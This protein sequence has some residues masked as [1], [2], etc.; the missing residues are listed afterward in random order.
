MNLQQ[1]Y[2]F[3]GT[4][5]KCL[6][7]FIRYRQEHGVYCT[8]CGRI[9]KHYYLDKPK[10]FRCATCGNT[11]SYRAGTLLYKSKMPLM[12]WFLAFYIL[13]NTKKPTS[14]LELQKLIGHKYY[15]PIWMMLH[16]IR[17]AMGTRDDM[18]PLVNLV[19]LDETYIQ[20]NI[21]KKGM[22]KT[23]LKTKQGKGTLKTPVLLMVEKDTYISKKTNL[24]VEYPKYIKAFALDSGWS[25]SDIQDYVSKNVVPSATLRTDSAPYYNI[26]TNPRTKIIASTATQVKLNTFL[27]SLHTAAGNMKRN[28]LGVY[29]SF[30]KDYQ[31]NYLNEFVYRFNRR[32]QKDPFDNIVRLAFNA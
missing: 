15:E 4:N 18:Y 1:F 19:E 16:K 2:K 30:H 7:Y 32:N 13:A 10:K 26:L 14:A 3:F 21:M 11:I 28:F 31:Q 24:P 20:A 27:G 8:K 17:F 6:R 5:A 12:Y 9:E 23:T 25:G 29:H 22:I